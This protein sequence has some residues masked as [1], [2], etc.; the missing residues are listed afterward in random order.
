MKFIRNFDIDIIRL[1]EGEHLF[2]FEIGE[3]FL[4]HFEKIKEVVHAAAIQVEVRLDKRINL[5]EVDF[6]VKGTVG[7]TCDRSLEK[8]DQGVD[9]QHKILYKYGEEEK[10][11]NEEVFLITKDT[12]AINVAQLM[13]EFIL[14]AIPAKKIHPD[15]RIE[16]EEAEEEDGWIVYEAGDEENED[17]TNKAEQ[18]PF[19]EALKNLKSNE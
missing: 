3:E 18:N 5:I 15:H 16:G 10:E 12:P 11:I 13:Y 9:V 4:A 14:L 19:W 6:D 1:K 17:D 2:H 8:F 7:L